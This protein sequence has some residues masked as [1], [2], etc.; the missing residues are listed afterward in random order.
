MAKTELKEE[1]AVSKNIID[2]ER[3]LEEHG[4]SMFNY[5]MLHLRD[6]ALAEELVQESLVSA[7][8]TAGNFAGNASERSWLIAILKHKIIDH[9]RKVSRQRKYSA[10][11][12]DDA[13]VDRNFSDDGHFSPPIKEWVG[14]PQRA[15]QQKDFQKVLTHCIGGLPERLAQ[16]FTLRE[17]EELE[18]EEICKLLEVSSTN[19]WVMLHRARLRLR[20]CLTANWFDE[21]S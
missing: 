20:K 10:D 6:T 4:N 11:L 13:F 17:L 8:R 5:A 19:L 14:D 21:Q 15:L 7:L 3:W 12:E 18:T 2:P 9:I 1:V 16:V